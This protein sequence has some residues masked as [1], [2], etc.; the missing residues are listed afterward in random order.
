MDIKKGKNSQFLLVSPPIYNHNQGSCQAKLLSNLVCSFC[1]RCLKKHI[2]FYLLSIQTQNMIETTKAK[3]QK[4]QSYANI[5]DTILDQKSP[6]HGEAVFPRLHTQTNK[7]TTSG[8]CNLETE[9]AQM[10]ESVKSAQTSHLMKLA[11]FQIF[12]IQVILN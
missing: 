10:A 5:R 11:L 12:N 3:K 4:L 2:F 1:F 9:Q 8:H 6:F 7:H